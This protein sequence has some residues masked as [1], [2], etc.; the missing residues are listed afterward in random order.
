[1]QLR[2]DRRANWMAGRVGKRRNMPP[3]TVVICIF[4]PPPKKKYAQDILPFSRATN[5]PTC[6]SFIFL[7]QRVMLKCYKKTFCFLTRL[8]FF[9]CNKLSQWPFFTGDKMSQQLPCASVHQLGHFVAGEKVGH[10]VVWDNLSPE[11][12][13]VGQWLFMNASVGHFVAWG[14]SGTI[15]R[16]KKSQWDILSLGQNVF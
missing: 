16:K 5:C 1:M 11:K 8:T 15:C 10:F 12:I 6:L 7:Q 9:T 3:D 13:P 14:E 4:S 2:E